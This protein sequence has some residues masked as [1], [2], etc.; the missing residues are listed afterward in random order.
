[1]ACGS[2]EEAV[3]FG[4]ALRGVG[5]AEAAETG[6]E[7]PEGVLAGLRDAEGF[8]GGDDAE[9]AGAGFDGPAKGREAGGGAI[10]GHEGLGEA[11]DM[12][13]DDVGAGFAGDGGEAGHECRDDQRGIA[14]AG[15]N[16]F[17]PGGGETGGEACDRPETGEFVLGDIDREGNVDGGQ[18]LGRGADDDDAVD[19]GRDGL[20][21]PLEEGAAPEEGGGLIAAEAGAAA[22]G[23]DHRVD[24]A[25]HGRP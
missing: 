7:R 14:G 4:E 19:G 13:P 18:W 20:G 10:D 21:D 5:V 22:A 2:A 15:E 25:V 1:M 23:E 17:G 9:A 12:R 11:A 24:I 6:V 3:D 16:E 8:A